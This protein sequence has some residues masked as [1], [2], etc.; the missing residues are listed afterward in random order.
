MSAGYLQVTM[1][2][3]KVFHL[4]LAS[5]T[6]GKF[7]GWMMYLPALPNCA[8]TFHNSTGGSR[9]ISLMLHDLVFPVA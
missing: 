4:Q 5:V 3:S 1:Y 9:T 6:V 2:M 8:L 7:A